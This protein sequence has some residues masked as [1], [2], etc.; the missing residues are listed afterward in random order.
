[1]SVD[2]DTVVKVAHLA[3]LEVGEERLGPLTDELNNILEWIETLSGVDTDN[4]PPMTSAVEA[5]LHW[6]GDVVTDGDRA[7]DVLSNAPQELMGFY[8]VP[9]VIE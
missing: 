6:R 2:K 3:A 1:M 8:A 5:E 9:K 4:V 7:A